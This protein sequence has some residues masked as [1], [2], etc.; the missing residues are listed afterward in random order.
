MRVTK[1]MIERGEQAWGDFVQSVDG[2]TIVEH[3]LR[4]ALNDPLEPE[5]PMDGQ[6][7]I[8]VVNGET[9]VLDG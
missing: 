7:S 4:R 8:G 1:Q 3:I 5:R 9:V 2:P 6:T